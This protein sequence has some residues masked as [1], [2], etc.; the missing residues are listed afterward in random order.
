MKS[1]RSLR[2]VSLLVE[3][4]A[5]HV[6]INQQIVLC[7]A[8]FDTDLVRPDLSGEGINDESEDPEPAEAEPAEPGPA[9]VN[10]KKRKRDPVAAKRPLRNVDD[11]RFAPSLFGA[12]I[13]RAMVP[14]CTYTP[15][16]MYCEVRCADKVWQIME[17]RGFN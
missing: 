10:A 16:R 4:R 15:T 9:T 2:W 11:Y 14:D 17:R 7:P 5:N 3:P 8:F 1:S 13:I 6:F 12:A